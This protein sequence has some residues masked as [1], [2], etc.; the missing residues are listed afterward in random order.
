MNHDLHVEHTHT[1]G[2]PLATGQWHHQ[3]Q[4]G[5]RHCGI[6]T[7]FVGVL[8]V[9]DGLLKMATHEDL[10]SLQRR[11][12]YRLEGGG[13]LAANNVHVC[14]ITMTQPSGLNHAAM[15][16]LVRI[17]QQ[18]HDRFKQTEELERLRGLVEVLTDRLQ[19]TEDE[20][21]RAQAKADFYEQQV[22]E[23]HNYLD[24]AC[25]MELRDVYDYQPEMDLL[26]HLKVMDKVP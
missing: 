5:C 15:Q 19:W 16:L 23:V 22:V 4:V 25:E 14:S 9:E 21:A 18:L 10:V 20:L 8:P 12:E 1:K 26:T 24:C 17:D 6:L 13:I 3:V 7:S 2:T 11:V